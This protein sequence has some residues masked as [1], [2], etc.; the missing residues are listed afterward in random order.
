M[1]PP[2]PSLL[3]APATGSLGGNAPLLLG[4][5][6]MLPSSPGVPLTGAAPPAEGRPCARP[7]SPFP[8][9]R[10]SSCLPSARQ[11]RMAPAVTPGRCLH[12]WRSHGDSCWVLAAG[13]GSG[14]GDQGF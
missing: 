6:V 13:R 7:L 8:V 12:S 11:L 10:S 5:W 2:A 14:R 9:T 3:L 1:N 4:R